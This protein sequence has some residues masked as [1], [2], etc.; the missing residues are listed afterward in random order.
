M[1]FGLDKQT[2]ADLN[3]FGTP[4][5]KHSV[6]DFF[7]QTQTKGGNDALYQLM[8]SPTNDLDVLVFRRNAIQTLAASNLNIRFNTNHFEFAEYYINSNI[9]VLKD[10]GISAYIRHFS[11]ILKSNNDYHVILRSKATKQSTIVNAV[12]S[13]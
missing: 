11:N 2:I 5:H 9:N 12:S 6:F 10:N 8:I 13:N 4:S 3:I 1:K 7:N